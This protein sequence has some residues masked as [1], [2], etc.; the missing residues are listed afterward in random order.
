MA[1]VASR[2]GLTTRGCLYGLA[3]SGGLS[4]DA[5][6]EAHVDTGR[7]SRQPSFSANRRTTSATPFRPLLVKQM[8]L[9]RRRKS[10]AVRP[11]AKRAVPPVGSTCEGPAT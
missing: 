9:E 6:V 10:F 2:V 11:L 1:L 5:V 8:T 3:C 4:V 7:M